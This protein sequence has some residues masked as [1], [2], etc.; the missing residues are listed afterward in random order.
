MI[1]YYNIHCISLYI[2]AF[3]SWSFLNSFPHSQSTGKVTLDSAIFFQWHSAIVWEMLSAPVL[4]LLLSPSSQPRSPFLQ[5]CRAYPAQCQH[6]HSK[7]KVPRTMQCSVQWCKVWDKACRYGFYMLELSSQCQVLHFCK[8]LTLLV[9]EA[10]ALVLSATVQTLCM[11]Q[12]LSECTL[13][14]PKGPANFHAEALP[15]CCNGVMG[16]KKGE[17]NWTH[18]NTK[19]RRQDNEMI[20][21]A[22]LCSGSWLH[23]RKSSLTFHIESVKMIENHFT[24][25]KLLQERVGHATANNDAI[26]LVNQILDE[27]DPERVAQLRLKSA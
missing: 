2:G 9:E 3:Q 15:W 17:K 22:R 8:L 19:Q 11:V 27:F 20:W 24:A 6:L 16:C 18:L 1:T 4:V 21:K 7:Y 14:A 26:C 5:P 25:T 13:G 12:R 10:L 23:Q